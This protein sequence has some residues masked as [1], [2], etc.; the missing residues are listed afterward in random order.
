VIAR[1]TAVGD[2]A[3]AGPDGGDLDS[4]SAIHDLVVAFYREVVFDELLAPMFGEVAEVDWSVHIPHLIDYWCRVLLGE[5]GYAG[6]IVRAHADL[7]QLEPLRPEHFD[8]WYGLWCR[9]IDQGW[10]G[11]VAER[12]KAHAAHMAATL[13]RRVAGETWAPAADQVAR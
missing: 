2:G 10:S 11:P 12:A 8:R 7:H 4:R 5:P 6:A 9:S 1:A 13:A 3:V